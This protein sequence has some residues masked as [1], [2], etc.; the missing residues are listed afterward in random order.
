MYLPRILLQM[1][2]PPASHEGQTVLHLVFSSDPIVKVTLLILIFFSITSWAIIFYKYNQVKKAKRSSVKFLETFDQAFSVEEVLTKNTPR[3]GNPL[4]QIFSSGISD[5]LRAKQMKS[6]DPNSKP[7]LNLEHI[8]K[9]IRRAESDEMHKLEQ[10]T[11]FLA[12]TASASPFIG[13][14]GTVWGILTAF[15]AI[16]Q[17]KSSSLAVVGPYIA[18]A[19]IAT[20]VGLAAAIPAVIAYNYFVT[21]IRDLNKDL[22]DFSV[23]LEHRIEKEYF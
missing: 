19:L 18:E 15:W 8:R 11:S 14:F 16:G 10:L 21:K 20:A 5:I 3:E 4:F 22:G 9:N 7:R 12:T 1:A 13:L 6:K 17:Q 2:V 23:D